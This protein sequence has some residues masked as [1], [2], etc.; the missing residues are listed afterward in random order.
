MILAFG[1]GG[2]VGTELER[3]GARVLGRR[4]ADLSDPVAA[5]EAIH[6]L[7]PAVVVNAAAWTDV[8]GAEAREADARAVNA[9]APGVMARACHALGIPFVHISTDYVFDG[10]G[11][12][13]WRP[14]DPVAPLGAYGR[15]KAE[16]EA[17]VRGAGGTH[18]ILRTSWVVSPQGRNFARTMLRLGAERQALR[19]VD[20]QHGAPTPARALAEAAIAVGERLA[21]DPELSGT[22]HLSGT[23]DT[24]WAGVAR[25]VMEA[26]GLACRIEPIP[27]AEYPTPA[28]RPL[29]SRL[30][31]AST[32]AAFGIA[33]PDWRAHL[34]SIVEAG[35]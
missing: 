29:N 34:S 32:E 17:L 23:P 27:S 5:G 1:R 18:A 16:G 11:D 33:R 24:T 22:Y 7:R 12:R 13:P 10:S 9:V 6:A 14:S 35:A 21:R 28:P 26:A 3:L 31:C 2:Q 20:D 8:D 30:D 19:V 25:A 4:R 15:T